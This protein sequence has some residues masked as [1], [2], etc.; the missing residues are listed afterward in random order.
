MNNSIYATL[1]NQVALNDELSI[2]ANNTANSNTAGFKK[3]MQV[4]SNYIAK[5]KIANL[6]MPNDIASISDFGPGALKQTGKT[7]DVAINGQGFF[8]VQTPH[9]LRYTRNGNFLTNNEG[10]LIDMQGNAVLS[11]DGAQTTIPLHD[12]N[13]FVNK[14]GKVYASGTEIG[15]IGVVDF[16]NQKLLRKTE[17]SYLMADVE[18]TPANGYQV[19]QGFI[20]ESNTNPIIETTKMIELQKKFSISSTLISDIYSMQGN[21]YRIIS[22]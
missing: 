11:Q 14:E 21:A 19:L 15:N 9:G 6:K 5:D 8:V 17:G 16:S 4:M 18:A 1:A 13:V 7:L 20:E 12:E 3:D 10:T 2:V 22:K